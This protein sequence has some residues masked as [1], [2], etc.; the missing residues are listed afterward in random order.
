MPE[1]LPISETPL[2]ISQ[3]VP[4]FTVGLLALAQPPVSYPR[5]LIQDIHFRSTVTE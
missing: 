2:N 3:Q 5:L 1:D 4:F